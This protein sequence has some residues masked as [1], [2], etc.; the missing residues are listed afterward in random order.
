MNRI[1]TI[2]LSLL[3]I[4]IVQRELTGSQAAFL[5]GGV[6][7]VLIVGILLSGVVADRLGGKK[8]LLLGFASVAVGFSFLPFSN[9]LG[10]IFLFAGL[11]QF[12]DAVIRVSLRLVLTNTV[13]RRFH[14]EAFGWLRMVNNA[15]QIVS[16]GLGAVASKFGLLPLML[17]D[18][19]TALG[20][21]ATGTRALPE[22]KSAR[23][24]KKAAA[25]PRETLG[26]ITRRYG[27]VLLA[28][29]A[30]A[31]VIAIWNFYY[32][33]FMSG[34]AGRLELLF[35][36]TGLRTF[37]TMMLVNTILCAAFAV[38]ASKWATRPSRIFG[39]GLAL[40]VAGMG[41]AVAQTSSTAWVLGAT[42]IV[43]GGELFLGSIAQ[44][45][46][47]RLLPDA[48]LEGFFYSV[49]VV[50]AQVGRI[51]GAALAFPWIVSAET[52]RFSPTPVFWFPL[53][54]ALGLIFY[55]RNRF[56]EA[57]KD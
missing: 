13:S 20:A 26:E 32:E 33:L 8:T 56:D 37:S 29:V 48:H 54:L 31:F 55:F 39:I 43:T 36:G 49:M 4:L 47:I 44:L 25:K 52:G 40:T 11:A 22:M 7:T 51:L 27:K 19:S 41:V 2:G 14:K 42:L 50:I 6:K 24:E 57:V 3:P 38:I 46:Q 18:A 30:C 53:A 15:G 12:G 28:P 5:L 21:I 23:R 16:F 1:G 17:F 34:I 35:P 45:L 10:S 9:R